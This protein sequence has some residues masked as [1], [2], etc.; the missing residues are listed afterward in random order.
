[1]APKPESNLRPVKLSRDGTF[2]IPPDQLRRQ[3]E[4]LRQSPDPQVRALAVHGEQLA[5]AI[6]RRQQNA[7]R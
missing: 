3:A 4:L 7:P 5:Q 6:E 1:M 2:L